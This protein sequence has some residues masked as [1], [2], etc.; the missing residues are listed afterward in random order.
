MVLLLTDMYTAISAKN[1][2]NKFR[3]KKDTYMPLVYEKYK[4]DSTRFYNSNSFYTSQIE[5]YNDILDQV[6]ENIQIQ[7]DSFKEILDVQD[8]IA[9]AKREIAKEKRR[10]TDSIRNLKRLIDRDSIKK[11][12]EVYFVELDKYFLETPLITSDTGTNE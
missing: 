1:V 2:R 7:Y 6:R 10:K 11:W 5:P 3:K 4:I 12:S 8:S 9:K